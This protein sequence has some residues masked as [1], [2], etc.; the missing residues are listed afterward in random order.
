[1]SELLA[2]LWGETRKAKKDLKKLEEN[3]EDMNKELEEHTPEWVK[4]LKA[5]LTKFQDRKKK[6]ERDSR[7][8]E[9]RCYI[10][11][12]L[13][14]G[15]AAQKPDKNLKD[16]SEHLPEWIKILEEI[17]FSKPP[18]DSKTSKAPSKSTSSK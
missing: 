12:C 5:Y 13:T 2:E 7:K 8:T 14:N 6:K 16:I 17:Y 18:L 10:N 15:D 1:M 3:L 11:S 4:I 9:R